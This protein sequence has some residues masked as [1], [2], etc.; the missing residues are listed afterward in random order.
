MF[1]LR[2]GLKA[3]ALARLRLALASGNQRP[4][5][6]PSQVNLWLRP[7]SQ[8]VMAFGGNLQRFLALAQPNLRPGRKPS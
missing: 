4:G 8:K 7:K 5:Q 2:L 1:W 3:M 6:K